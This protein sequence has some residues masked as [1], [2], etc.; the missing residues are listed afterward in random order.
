M[1]VYA[2]TDKTVSGVTEKMAV[3]RVTISEVAVTWLC[4]GGF[5]SKMAVC[6]VTEKI[7]MC[8]VTDKMAVCGV[9]DKMAMCGAT[10]RMTVWN[11]Q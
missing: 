6:G 1:A 10:D 7:A 9:T 2:V 8:G 5:A 4:G 3:W 11:D